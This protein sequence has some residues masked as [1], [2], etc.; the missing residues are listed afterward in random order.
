MLIG[1]AEQPDGLQRLTDA[2]AKLDW[3]ARLKFQ[4]AE[5]AIRW[6]SRPEVKTLVAIA[7]NR[8][9]AK[10]PRDFALPLIAAQ[11][12]QSKDTNDVMLTVIGTA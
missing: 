11:F 3:L 8:E 4:R 6:K 5:Q 1:R 7:N 12:T 10:A 9:L 2:C